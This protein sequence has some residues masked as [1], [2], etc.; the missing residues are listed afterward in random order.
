VRRI[1]VTGGREFEGAASVCH[2][3]T[4]YVHLDDLIVEGGARGADAICRAEAQLRGVK[5]ET[6]SADWKRH[7]KAAG[8]IRNQEMVDSGLDLLIA[9]PGGK[10]TADMVRRAEN[11][12]ITVILS[13]QGDG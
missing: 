1:G 6:H 13:A 4:T 7:G 12:G 3:F 9:F 5:V 10:G 11:A 2:A 8:F